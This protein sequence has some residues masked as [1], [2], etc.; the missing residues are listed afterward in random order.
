MRPDPIVI[1]GGGPAG[2]TAAAM[3]ARSGREVTLFEG[4]AETQS[5]CC[6]CCLAPRALS[7]LD[8]LG[9]RGVVAHAA[10]ACTQRWRLHDSTGV[11]ML[12]ESLGDRAGWIVDRA[13]MD[14]ALRRVARESGAVVV[15]GAATITRDFRASSRACGAE[16]ESAL[17]IGADGVGSGVARAFGMAAS[18]AS[19]RERRSAAPYRSAGLRRYGVSWSISA[20]VGDSI[21]VPERSIEIHLARGGYLGL[22]RSEDR[23]VV[24]ALIDRGRTRESSSPLEVIRRWAL[25]SVALRP[26]LEALPCDGSIVG[27]HSSIASTMHATGPLPWRP[28]RVA[29][30]QGVAAPNAPGVAL[31]GDAAGYEEPFTGEG[32][33]WAFEGAELLASHVI[34]TERWDECA[35]DRYAAAHRA[36]FAGRQRRLRWLG[37]V[38]AAAGRRS[39]VATLLRAAGSIPILPGAIV[40]RVVAA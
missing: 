19:W 22:V 15:E 32:M 18:T 9:L 20:A 37:G 39:A 25:A 28:A 3:L 11:L 34:A 14:A 6:G 13:R 16:L 1:V 8:R 23:V 24:A 30:A 10:S 33:A 12:D 40:R 38:G 29:L 36:R 31:V 17:V 35:A 2:A 7:T 27:A 26:L 4:R 21:G 5:K